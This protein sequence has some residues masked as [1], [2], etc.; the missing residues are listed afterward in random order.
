MRQ[1]KFVSLY[2]QDECSIIGRVFKD[3]EAKD[4]TDEDAAIILSNPNFQDVTVSKPAASSFAK[5]D[6]KSDNLEG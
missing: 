3:G 2:G 6:F 5:S 1:V 4:V